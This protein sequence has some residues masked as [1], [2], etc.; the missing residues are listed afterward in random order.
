MLIECYYIS[1]FP[2]HHHD[3]ILYNQF[4]FISGQYFETFR[5]VPQHRFRIVVECVGSNEFDIGGDVSHICSRA[6]PPCMRS[7]T[8]VMSVRSRIFVV[9]HLT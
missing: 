6:L 2:I 8:T 3:V 4:L 1:I 7:N 9:N 5:S